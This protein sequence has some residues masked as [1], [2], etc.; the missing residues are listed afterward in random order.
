MAQWRMVN[1]FRRLSLFHCLNGW[2]YHPARWYVL[3]AVCRQQRVAETGTK[4]LPVSVN[5]SRVSL[6]YS[7]VVE[8]MKVL[9]GRLTLIRNT[10]SWK[11]Q[12]VQRLIIMKYLIC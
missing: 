2:K 10:F 3:K 12:K 6:Y 9:S 8:N 5:I 7:S 1:R 11:L 4:M